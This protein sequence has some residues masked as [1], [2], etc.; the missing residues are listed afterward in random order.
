[1]SDSVESLLREAGVEFEV[2]G[3]MEKMGADAI[4]NGD[5]SSL[6]LEVN[7]NGELILD[8]AFEKVGGEGGE[9]E[10]GGDEGEI[11][12][13]DE[14]EGGEMAAGGDGEG[15]EME[16][17][18][19]GDFEELVD[20]NFRRC[21][22]CQQTKHKKSIRRHIRDVH[23][24]EKVTCELCG[25]KLTNMNKLRLHKRKV[26]EKSK[27]KRVK[28]NFCDKTFIDQQKASFH[29]TLTHQEVNENPFE[30]PSCEKS[31]KTKPNLQ[32]H[33]RA[34]HYL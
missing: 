17:G 13:G 31:F 15:G 24:N 30:C 14:G 1:M 23:R 3:F 25:L 6:G 2:P 9:L 27:A 8:I 5:L 18:G 11:K 4:C 29:E 32:R 12:A 33:V 20:K 16:A 7:D 34:K 28:C 26:H 19:D 22:H 21:P 10:F